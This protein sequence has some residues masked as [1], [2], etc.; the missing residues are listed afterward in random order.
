MVEILELVQTDSRKTGANSMQAIAAGS[1][2]IWK[3]VILFKFVIGLQF[4][5]SVSR[6]SLAC[7]TL[8]PIIYDH[9]ININQT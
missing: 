9:R 8:A 7:K 4:S 6:P 1:V 3:F 5:A 2:L